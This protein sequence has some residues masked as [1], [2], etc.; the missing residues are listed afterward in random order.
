MA[1]LFTGQGE[2]AGLV[3]MAGSSPVVVVIQLQ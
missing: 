1:L 2:A 3:K